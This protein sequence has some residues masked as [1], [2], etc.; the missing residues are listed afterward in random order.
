[1]RTWLFSHTDGEQEEEFDSYLVE[2]ISD[3]RA[4]P[5]ED[6]I[7]IDARTRSLD[8]ESFNYVKSI[9]KSNRVYVIGKDFS[10][11]PIGLRPGS[12]ARTN[13]L[14]EFEVRVRFYFKEEVLLNV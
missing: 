3:I 12:I 9:L 7:M 13:K 14:K 1:M 2:S 8:S 11:T 4:V 5:S 10:K 6:R